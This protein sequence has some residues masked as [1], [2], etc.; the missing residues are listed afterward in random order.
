MIIK[1]D[2]AGVGHHPRLQKTRLILFG[3]ALK[4]TAVVLI[5][6]LIGVN[7]NWSFGLASAYENETISSFFEVQDL[8]ITLIAAPVLENLPL[9]AIVA[10]VSKFTLS[11]NAFLVLCVIACGIYGFTVHGYNLGAINGA[12]LFSGVGATIVAS[13][14]YGIKASYVDA[15]IVHFVFNAVSIVFSMMLIW[16]Y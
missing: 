5:F 14:S 1:S 9:L 11:K 3:L 7:P 8:L 13:S 12:V 15:L 10:V 6:L 2:L 4:V 16:I